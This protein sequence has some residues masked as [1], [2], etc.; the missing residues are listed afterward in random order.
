MIFLQEISIK[1]DVISVISKKTD[2][3][4][5]SSTFCGTLCRS[6]W[7]LPKSQQ[8]LYKDRQYLYKGYLHG[9]S[10]RADHI[11]TRIVYNRSI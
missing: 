9:L 10:T 3:N 8:R 6:S 11:S 5:N 7:I 4:W 2:T 1:T